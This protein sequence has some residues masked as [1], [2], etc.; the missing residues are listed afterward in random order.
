MSI[1][2]VKQEFIRT[3][4]GILSFM[5]VNPIIYTKIWCM[6]QRELSWV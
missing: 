6:W 5:K 3:F 1:S 4:T 2:K